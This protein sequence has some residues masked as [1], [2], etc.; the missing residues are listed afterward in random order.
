MKISRLFCQRFLPQEIPA[1]PALAAALTARG[2]EVEAVTP[3]AV[4]GNII[5]GEITACAPHP[6]ADRLQL[7]TVNIGGGGSGGG[8]GDGGEP[9]TLVCGAPNARVGLRVAVAVAG[10]ATLGGK[11]MKARAIR[12]VDSAGMICS[13]SELGIGEEQGGVLELSPHEGA[14]GDLLDDILMLNDDIL[15]INITP[16]RGDCFS[17][18]GI[19][20]EVAAALGCA[21]KLPVPP[22]LAAESDSS[23]EFPVSIDAAARAACPYYGCVV[24]RDV[25]CD[26]PLPWRWR[27]LLERCG[28]RPVSAVV[29]I[30]NYIM[31]AYGQPLHAFDLDKI[32]PGGI[33]VRFAREGEALPLLDGSEATCRADTLL[34]AAA[35][36][37]PLALGGVMGGAESAISA[38][39]KNVLLEG[40]H[41]APDVVAG[42]TRQFKINSEA[43][44]RFERGVDPH[45]PPLALAQAAAQ[46]RQICGGTVGKLVGSCGAPPPPAP[47]IA[48][49]AARIGRLLG[50][51]VPVDAA[52]EALNGIAVP[53][54][55]LQGGERIEVQPPSW[56]FD[57]K[58]PEDVIEEVVRLHGYDNLPET[59]PLGMR[60]L[61]DTPPTL[62]AQAR[63]FFAARGF[64]EIITYAFV[65]PM[66][67]QALSTVAAQP[68][69]NPM[70][71]E[72]SVMRTTLWGGLLDRARFNLSH[73]QERICLFEVGRC[74]LPAA[75]EAGGAGAGEGALP[76][77][78]MMVGGLLHGQHL[79]TQWSAAGR[80]V[81]FYDMKGVVE[82]FL[83]PHCRPDAVEFKPVEAAAQPGLHPGKA[84]TLLLDGA[85][86]GVLGELHP[87]NPLGEDFKTPP[88]LFALDLEVLAAHQARQA[89]AQGAQEGSGGGRVTFTQISRL[90]PLWRDLALIADAELP[91][92]ELLA[93][94]RAV[95]PACVQE[96]RLFDFFSGGD[97]PGERLPADKK[98][99]G[100]RFLLQGR[101]ATL[102]GE[103]I[104]Q[105]MAEVLEG[106]KTRCNV[107]LRS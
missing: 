77:Q 49:P 50:V 33:H 36:G 23:E 67:E 44:F 103:E 99:C 28:G 25:A 64:Y 45:L 104:E 86:L 82:E 1:A 21:L 94:A 97:A 98:S 37:A 2:L 88:L 46:V 72:M 56:R 16:N 15:E 73:R 13:A 5:A 38:A 93:A 80:Q 3:A 35:D 14:P 87:Q 34:I 61:R 4:A 66:W 107:T 48:F 43:A 12:N 90:P 26:R 95:A 106:L 60:D 75:T 55:P 84:A 7:C 17:H 63:R 24:M 54:Q 85:P 105:A 18:L 74:F 19:A 6:N 57:L 51:Q 78:P 10:R 29:D 59:L 70:S 71:E 91:V 100:L 39:T 42:R 92:G 96:V 9:L 47:P 62:A 40:A 102:T 76:H 41:F 58:I 31:L 27:T 81:D 69:A 79:P 101:D 83:Q 20:R 8:S 89:Q 30:T 68:L 53:T 65:A 32:A 22:E 11:T 52:V